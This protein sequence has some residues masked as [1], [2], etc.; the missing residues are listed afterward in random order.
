MNFTTSPLN[1]EKITPESQTRCVALMLEIYTL[2]Q[3]ISEEY[4]KKLIG[5][6]LL[7]SS[8]SG[9]AF[10][11]DGRTSACSNEYGMEEGA[12]FLGVTT[13]SLPTMIVDGQE[14][15]LDS[16]AAMS[17]LIAE[18]ATD[19]SETPILDQIAATLEVEREAVIQSV[20][21]IL[22]DEQELS[23]ESIEANL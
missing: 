5:T 9:H 17:A 7:L 14:T 11:L 3:K 15:S 23:I 12:C 10:L 8:L 1:H 13:T 20:T 21:N 2:K 16:E 18:L 22:A 19:G 6:I 4:M